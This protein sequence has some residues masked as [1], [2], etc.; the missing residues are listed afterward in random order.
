MTRDTGIGFAEMRICKVVGLTQGE[1]DLVEYVVLDEVSGD[2]H[3]LIA[4][5]EMEALNLAASLNGT[6]WPRPMTYQFMA[7]LVRSLGGRVREVRLDRLVDD[8]YAASVEVEG[9]HGA[10]LVDARAS[11]ALNLAALVDAR[12]SAA[13]EVLAD[14]A[15]QQEGDSA[16]ATMMRRALAAR[17]MTIRRAEI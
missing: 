8:A 3:L 6:A 12:V 4:I 16:E 1:D 9:P 10:E 11:D 5:G 17:S 2:R 13:P 7:A 15:R 14:N